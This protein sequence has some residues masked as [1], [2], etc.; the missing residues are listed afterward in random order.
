MVAGKGAVLG[1]N[2]IRTGRRG[3]LTIGDFSLVNCRISFDRP[4]AS[5]RIGDRCHIGKSNLVAADAITIEDDVLISWG[6]TIND[7]NSHATD[8]EFRRNDMMDWHLGRKDWTNVIARPVVIKRRSWVGFNATILKGVT[9]GEGAIVAACAV[10]TK[11]V[12]PYTIVGG[13]PA[14]RIGMAPRTDFG[15]P[16]L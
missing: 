2:S 9:I 7:N 13:N 1:L 11:D 5:I 10:V 8:W 3:N 6:V 12:P 16:S 14:T 4:Q 15:D